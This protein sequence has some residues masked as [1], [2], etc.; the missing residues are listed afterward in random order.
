ML[1]SRHFFQFHRH[2]EGGRRGPRLIGRQRLLFRLVLRLN[3]GL[4]GQPRACCPKCVRRARAGGSF[5][6]AVAP[7][8]SVKMTCPTFIFSPSLTLTSFTTPLTDDGTSTTALSVSSSI[9]GWPSETRAPGET[10]R[11]TRS[12]ESMFSPSSGS[13]NSP[14]NGG[15]RYVREARAAG[16]GEADER[17]RAEE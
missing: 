12:P 10:I 3:R 2:A 6:G 13:L 17:Q 14:L 8:S 1:G 11:R 7:P 16:D 5:D 4:E 15:R 9:T